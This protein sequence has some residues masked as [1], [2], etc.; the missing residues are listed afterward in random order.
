M[1]K[2]DQ[3]NAD[4]YISP[5]NIPCDPS[6][7]IY[8]CDLGSSQNE[9]M[10]K[11]G[12]PIAE[13]NLGKNKSGLLYN[14]GLSLLLFW[15]N[16]LGG[17][18]FKTVNTQGLLGWETNPNNPFSNLSLL[19]KSTNEVLPF[20]LKNSI[21]CGQPIAYAK[22]ILGEKLKKS[23][24]SYDTE[25]QYLYKDGPSVVIL[26]CDGNIIND[27]EPIFYKNAGSFD[28]SFIPLESNII[29]TIRITPASEIY[30]RNN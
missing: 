5:F 20:I 18:I 2:N 4:G 29:H 19:R 24:I 9:V 6:K 3:E 16:K 28:E 17:G 15:N 12:N 8:G 13:L 10:K 11:L 27:D 23:V 30:I 1:P 7:S 14:K 21:G 22:G 25:H 26:D